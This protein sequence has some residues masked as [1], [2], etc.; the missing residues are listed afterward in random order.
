[1]KRL[2]WI[3]LF[4]F[5]T[6]ML[7]DIAYA[8]MGPAILLE[9]EIH[10]VFLTWIIGL[11]EGLLLCTLFRAWRV[12]SW[13]NRIFFSMIAANITSAWLGML[14]V[15]SRYTVQIMGDV[16]IENLI[17]AFWTMVY[18]TFVLT[19]IIEFPF[20]LAALYG[21]KWLIPKALVATI[22]LHCIS[23]SLL[24][25]FYT[26]EESINMVT[27]LEVVPASTF[28][29]K[30]DYDLYYISPDGKQVLRSDLVGN[31]KEVVL[32]L[33]MQGVPD[34]LCACPRKVIEETQIERDTHYHRTIP[35]SICDSESDLYVLVNI[36][37]T[38]ESHLLI[39]KFSPCSALR[40]WDGEYEG[41][42]GCCI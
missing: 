21:R 10:L 13:R 40:I 22:F 26:G 37:G 11:G 42:V 30:E 2:R 4:A 20:F 31:G 29:M 5:L 15:K 3:F 1:M 39:E 33:G 12:P 34:R 41:G 25:S 17:P 6:T 19:M 38:F 36:D 16:T 23:Y 35:R 27:E 8:N 32:A 14:F 7:P 18:V 9:F 24:F 28:E